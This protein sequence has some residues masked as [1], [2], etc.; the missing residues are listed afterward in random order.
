M[1]KG[2]GKG[3]RKMKT[4]PS[5]TMDDGVWRELKIQAIREKKTASDIIENLIRGYLKKS[6]KKGA[7]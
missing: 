7:N 1:N 2:K 3:G 6:K 5:I 4:A